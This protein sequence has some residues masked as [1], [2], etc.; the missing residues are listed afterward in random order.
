MYFKNLCLPQGHEDT[1]Y[2][3]LY[4]FTFHNYNSSI[5]NSFIWSEVEIKIQLCFSHGYL[6]DLAQFI[7]KNI[8]C[9]LH[10]N[11]T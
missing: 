5:I 9:S 11:V 10:Y 8:L 6:I 1:V 2:F 7:E 3:Q 4:C